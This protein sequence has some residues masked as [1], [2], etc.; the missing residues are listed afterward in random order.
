M[1]A[2]CPVMKSLARAPGIVTV[3][4]R[5][6]CD[7]GR[8]SVAPINIVAKLAHSHHGSLSPTGIF[9]PGGLNGHW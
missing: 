7:F 1:N 4:Q 2:R 5:H 3:S 6:A 8:S 9:G